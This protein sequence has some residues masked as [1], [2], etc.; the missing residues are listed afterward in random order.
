MKRLCYASLL[1]VL[2]YCKPQDITQREIN[3]EM[4]LS[5]DP[6]YDLM[7]DDNAAS[8][9]A[10]ADRNI[11]SDVIS[12]ARS[13]Q[14]DLVV[15]HVR[16][17]VLLKLNESKIK[18]VVLALLDILDNDKTIPDD[19]IIFYTGNKTKEELINETLFDP[20]EIIANLFLYAIL[21]TKNT[22]FKNEVKNI[23]KK[24]VDSFAT[25]VKNISFKKNKAISRV[26]IKK[27]IQNKDFNNT[28]IEVTHPET[29]GLKNNNEL[30]VFHLN[31][32]NNKFS[33]R[34]LQKF[35]LSNIGRYVYSRVDIEKFKVD[36]D[37][38]L[39][40]YNAL[41]K[42]HKHGNINQFKDDGLGDMMLY[43]FLEQVLE[44]PKIMSKVELNT[45]AGYYG[46]KSDGIHL[47]GIDDGLGNP[48]H[49]LIFGASK[50]IGD[51]HSA[52]DI[53]MGKAYEIKD[54][55]SAEL[56]IME[57]TLLGRVFDENTAEYMKDIVIPGRSLSNSVDHAFGIFLGYTLDIDPSDLTNHEFRIEVT[58][59]MS[60][61]LKKATP[62]IVNKINSL[63]MASF[64]FYFYILPFNDAVVDKEDIIAPLVRG[65]V[66]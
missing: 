66:I 55:P 43:A 39:I 32:L 11:P 5:I 27:T 13:V 53:A 63:G 1:K 3:G 6:N 52:I 19:T 12:K 25:E 21:N 44:A 24:Y 38:E 4:L 35:I 33:V 61:D 49:Q 10:S 65:G 23:S 40:A 8:T 64:S 30:R 26:S 17:Y 57:S 60:K 28:F 59:R 42:L 56:S 14:V 15:E 41:Q 29:L 48:Y 18:I 47:L 54:D 31:I 51:L 34:E 58:K 37:V 9:L 16:D 50:I 2:Y 7:A 20:A 45:T 62:Y 46:S 36:G 22:D